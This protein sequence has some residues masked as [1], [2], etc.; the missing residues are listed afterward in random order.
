MKK[1]M[2]MY[3]APPAVIAEMMKATPDQMKAEMDD[4]M[5][6]QGRHKKAIVD[7]GAPLGKTKRVATGGVSDTRNDITGYAIVEAESV[8]GA[9]ALFKDHPHLKIRGTSVDILECLDVNAMMPA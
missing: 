5:A 2:A 9:A 7:F 1:F 3:M 8:E 6:W 4:W